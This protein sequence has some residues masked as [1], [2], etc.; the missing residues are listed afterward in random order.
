[1]HFLPRQS[2]ADFASL[3]DACDVM[4]DTPHFN[5]MNTSLEAFA[6]GVPVVTSPTELQRGRHTT[7]MYRK[8][9][10]MECVAQTGEDYVRLALRLGRDTDYR[11]HV[12]GEIRQR[13]EALFEDRRAVEQFERFFE[14]V[15]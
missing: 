3:I 8:M 6:L 13:S 15:R 1:V 4:L 14:S 2:G 5:G 7:G 12:R 11:R 9:G 10:F